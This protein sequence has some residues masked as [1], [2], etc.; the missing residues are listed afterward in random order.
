M[1]IKKWKIKIID[2]LFS[3]KKISYNYFIE[4]QKISN[5]C[6]NWEIS[7]YVVILVFYPYITNTL[8]G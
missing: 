2:C 6:P 7:V 8:P 3:D 5:I 1:L 4:I